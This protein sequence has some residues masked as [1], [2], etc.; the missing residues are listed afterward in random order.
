M[1]L[2]KRAKS[3]YVDLVP[4]TC[5]YCVKVERGGRTPDTLNG[6]Y[7]SKKLATKAIN[8]YLF[9]GEQLIKVEINAKSRSNKR[10]K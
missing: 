8:D 9:N 10:K 4:H 2:T 6:K 1:E 5:L 3:F 7:T